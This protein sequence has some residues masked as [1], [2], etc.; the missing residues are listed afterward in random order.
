MAELYT[1]NENFKC[2][3]NKE[4][5]VNEF[6]ECVKFR[7]KRKIPQNLQDGLLYWNIKCEKVIAMRTGNT[8]ILTDWVIVTSFEDQDGVEIGEWKWMTATCPMVSHVNGIL[9]SLHSNDMCAIVWW[10]DEMERWIQIHTFKSEIVNSRIYL[11]TW[12]VT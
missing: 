3:N 7:Q 2:F 5:N 11:T 6:D 1:K 4:R 9:S 10:G 8:H 12:W